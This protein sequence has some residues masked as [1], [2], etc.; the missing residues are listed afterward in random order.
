[1][2]ANP[3]LVAIMTGRSILRLKK[4]CVTL[5]IYLKSEKK[6]HANSSLCLH[7]N[8][9]VM[10]QEKHPSRDDLLAFVRAELD[11][12]THMAV[13]K[14]IRDCREC[15]DAM[16]VL[17]V[18]NWQEM[19]LKAD[20]SPQE[21]R[22][23]FATNEF[24]SQHKTE[25]F[26]ISSAHGEFVD[27]PR[28]IGRY[29]IR[30]TLGSGAFGRVYLAYDPATDRLVALKVPNA[31]LFNDGESTGAFLEEARNAGQLK[32]R[33][34]VSVYDVQ[35][36][37]DHPY[38]VQEYID[39][40]NLADWI[41][42]KQPDHVEIV[43]VLIEIAEAVGFAHQQRVYHR[44]LKPANV[45]I[46]REGHAHVADF[47]IALRESRQQFGKRDISG[48]PAYMSPEQ[49]RGEIN[50][51]DGRTD[52]W[53]FGVVMY[54]LLVGSRPFRSKARKELF[55]EIQQQDPKPPRQLNPTIAK[56]L[57]RIC[58]KCLEKL[59]SYRY[60]AAAD[61]C[62]DLSHWYAHQSSALQSAY[63]SSVVVPTTGQS[64][65]HKTADTDRQ[66]TP[67][68]IVPK[69]LRA[70]DEGDADFF[71]Q[72]LPGPRDREGLPESIGFWKTR[73]ERSNLDERFAV[74]MI[75]G[76]SGCGKSSF[77]KAGLLPRLSQRILP[78]Y[79]EATPANT[80]RRILDAMAKC[81]PEVPSNNSL[82]EIIRLKRDGPS[83]G[84]KVLLVIDQ[85]EQW[86]Q[87]EPVDLTTELV[88]ALRHCD[89]EHIQCIVMVRDDFWMSA[90]RFMQ[91]LEIP[92]LE[93]KN[94]RAVDL[95][96]PKHARYVLTAFGQAYRDVENPPTPEQ[97]A[98]IEKTV[99]N[100]SINGKVIS[101][102]LAL[103]AQMMHGR[104]WSDASVPTIE[105]IGVT[106][107]EETFSVSTASPAHRFHQAA[108]RR[109]LKSLLPASS[110]LKGR[111]RSFEELRNSSGYANR[112]GDFEAVL[113][114]LDRQ[115]RLI[116][117]IDRN[118]V[119]EIDEDTP[120]DELKN[121]PSS[122]RYFQLTH[123]YL[124]PALRE[125]LTRKQRETRRGRAELRLE[126]CA[127]LWSHKRERKL[128]PGYIDTLRILLLTNRRQ[129]NP[130]QRE[131][132]KKATIHCGGR[133]SIVALLMMV[134]GAFGITFDHRRKEAIT[135]QSR[136]IR[137][138]RDLTD[139]L[140]NDLFFE[141]K[142]IPGVEKPLISQ[143]EKT[144]AIYENLTSNDRENNELMFE[145]ARIHQRKG[146]VYELLEQWS[147]AEKAFSQSSSILKK[148]TAKGTLQDEIA[149][150][151]AVSEMRAGYVL[152]AQDDSESAAAR[153]A[154]AETLL[155]QTGKALRFSP[156]YQHTLGTVLYRRCLQ[157]DHANPEKEEMIRRAVEEFSS[158]Y[159]AVPGSAEFLSGLLA[160][161]QMLRM[162]LLAE[163]RL[164]EAKDVYAS[165]LAEVERL[166]ENDDQAVLAYELRANT[167]ENLASLFRSSF[168]IREETLA[169]QAAIQDYQRLIDA[170]PL[171]LRY[172]RSLAISQM[173]L[174]NVQRRSG[175]TTLAAENLQEA[176]ATL[177][178]LHLSNPQ[179]APDRESFASCLDR[180]T[181]VYVELG[182]AEAAAPLMEVAIGHFG[183]LLEDGAESKQS[184]Y[185]ERLAFAQV[186][187]AQVAHQLNQPDAAKES[188]SSA[189][190]ILQE[191][192]EQPNS[193]RRYRDEL[194]TIY[195]A[196]AELLEGEDRNIV[197]QHA[198]ENWELAMTGEMIP[199][200]G[201]RYAWFLITCPDTELNDPKKAIEIATLL[202]EASE[203]NINI[204]GLL[205]AANL[206][207]GNSDES[208]RQLKQCINER[209]MTDGLV[210]L[211]WALAQHE[212][213][214]TQMAS[215]TLEK[216]IN[217]M[218]ESRPGSVR[219][220]R[221][222]S[223][224]T[225]LMKS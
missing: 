218:K 195:A 74:G 193:I 100:L 178:D 20:S 206:R 208:V 223:E 11:Q 207:N 118:A 73:I 36:D 4:L 168:R 199:D 222:R 212:C 146:R 12:D 128:L 61:L 115:L 143:L 26:Q 69:G 92:L 174:G 184:E 40:C 38:I 65:T 137:Q 70:F 105:E 202:R 221:L 102:R 153:F 3:P 162:W 32:H 15:C 114:L 191:L 97:S 152:L 110:V 187:S 19:V 41:Q 35:V 96:S 145:L 127:R 51:I 116:I 194:A 23:E 214:Q 156:R 185:R 82:S 84:R 104:V 58:L 139:S 72:L 200:I 64:D 198:I 197:C 163:G 125:W 14:H 108:A 189:A 77:M 52:L 39:G 34:L 188:F 94:S 71:L 131:M 57:E 63:V 165:A 8:E 164:D 119:A 154:A 216:A 22:D 7:P 27:A 28:Q 124:V 121:E 66:S 126:E 85:F 99:D 129:W 150:E 224:I 62:E 86:L 46:D 95:F 10:E 13:E 166:I 209:G 213:G 60:T 29:E 149:L 111:M 181:E 6:C 107:L 89:G 5:N 2:S 215:Q 130:P 55:E 161:R 42:Q 16:K 219:H 54:E 49:V 205:G 88:E 173:N 138:T 68:P 44:D 176:A 21:Q 18:G 81:G 177:E 80:H 31:T 155:N 30:D 1:M 180:L 179:F 144:A 192:V 203:T 109:I 204:I 120:S 190:K 201:Q 17:S 103:L 50:R 9:F 78:I 225:S 172:R 56:E 175:E 117:P 171:R 122:V 136:A 48:S 25:D 91:A 24:L 37:G 167:Q 186:R 211:F 112:P 169:L 67:P 45:L 75:Y 210:T 59:Q 83:Y 98:F 113:D 76:P 158:A 170:K 140:M 159:S 43:R 147:E 133:L 182:R 196:W 106:F 90:T 217:R 101:V 183:L 160:A 79:V 93:D 123:D 157:I 132:M 53:S 220:Q 142:E 148:I 47:G 141:L 135:A 33:G 151:S 134:V 87:S